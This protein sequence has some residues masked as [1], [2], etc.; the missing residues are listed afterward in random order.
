MLCFKHLTLCQVWRIKKYTLRFWGSA[1][2]ERR[3]SISLFLIE[4]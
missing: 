1:P 2:F 4:A 3:G